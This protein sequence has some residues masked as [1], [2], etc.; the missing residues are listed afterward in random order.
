[1]VVPD[2]A[3]LVLAGRDADGRLS[4]CALGHGERGDGRAVVG[5]GLRRLMVRARVKVQKVGERPY[6]N[7]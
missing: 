3:R 7:V 5:E 1:M 2:D 4:A 6:V